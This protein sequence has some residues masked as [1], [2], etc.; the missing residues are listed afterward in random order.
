[1]AA[2]LDFTNDITIS[3]NISHLRSNTQ[4]FT[5]LNAA[6][7]PPG[8]VVPR[9]RIAYHLGDVTSPYIAFPEPLAVQ[10]Q[11]FVD[12]IVDGRYPTTDMEPPFPSRSDG[13]YV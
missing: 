4:I 7:I 8:D 5:W 6:G 2:S 13:T 3:V 9:F 11:H 10:D 1:L 12:C